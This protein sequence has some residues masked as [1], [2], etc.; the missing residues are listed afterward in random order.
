MIVRKVYGNENI[1]R[2]KPI[3]SIPKSSKSICL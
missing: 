2:A 1:G 3:K